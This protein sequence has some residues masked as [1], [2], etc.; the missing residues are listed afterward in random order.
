MENQAQPT[1]RIIDLIQDSCIKVGD[2]QSLLDFIYCLSEQLQGLV[3]SVLRMCF[4]LFF[5]FKLEVK[6]TITRS[7]NS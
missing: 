4:N 7:S 1:T 2:S 5:A 3:R 6:F